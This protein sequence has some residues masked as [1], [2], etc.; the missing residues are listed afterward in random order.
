MGL[1]FQ[2]KFYNIGDAVFIIK[3]RSHGGNCKIIAI[4]EKPDDRT[5]AYTLF[6]K[7]KK[8]GF[9]E[10]M[11]FNEVILKGYRILEEV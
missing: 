8:Y 10:E 1:T 9:V 7:L 3:N 4:I 6:N 5:E 11:N 2:Q